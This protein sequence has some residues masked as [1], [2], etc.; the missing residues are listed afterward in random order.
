MT[1]NRIT[2]RMT[3]LGEDAIDISNHLLLVHCL[4]RVTNPAQDRAQVD[5]PL[6]P[7]QTVKMER[8]TVIGLNNTNILVDTAEHR[9][10]PNPDIMLEE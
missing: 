5:I 9:V 6:K 8:P 3:N 7:E 1:S 10:L 4:I 2:I